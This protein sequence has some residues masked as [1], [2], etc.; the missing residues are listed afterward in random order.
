MPRETGTVTTVS[1][2][3]GAR[4]LGVTL[5]HE[6]LLCD[7]TGFASHGGKA[8]SSVVDLP[9][10]EVD[11][12]RGD[13]HSNPD[14]LRLDDMQSA[15]EELAAA[16]SAG[17]RTLVELTT[18][19]MGRNPE[20][21]AEIANRADVNVV[22]GAGMYVSRVHTPDVPQLTEA[23]IATWIVGDFTDGGSGSTVRPGVIGEI[24]ISHPAGR[25]EMKV[26]RAAARVQAELAVG[27]F[28]HLPAWQRAGG[29]VLDTIE[30]AGGDLTRTV[31]CHMNPSWDD[32]DYQRGLLDRGA[33]L[34]YD[35][36][37]MEGVRY[38]AFS[39][40]CPTD[41]DSARALSALI[42]AGY[43]DRLVVSQDV[44]TKMQYGRFGGAGYG[45][46][47]A[48]DCA[49][50]RRHGIDSK[51][52]HQLLIANPARILTGACLS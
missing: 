29:V 46:L 50:L 25:D 7:L 30:H 24:G 2:E 32:V 37:G 6:H 5:M 35:M 8:L 39:G 47:L 12:L 14:N 26:L 33:T 28:I 51:G 31:L 13:P 27:L 3:L 43:G 49:L 40:A 36:F 15:V 18:P 11:A 16:R 52:L 9:Q 17:C 10:D 20:R 34:S 45:Y 4:Q 22:M 42:H 48:D 19:D 1:G 23:Q 44:F 38:P 21:L 41:A